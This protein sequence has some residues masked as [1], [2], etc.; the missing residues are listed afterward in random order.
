MRLALA[1]VLL[2]SAASAD[3]APLLTQA[4]ARAEAIAIK[5]C[6]YPEDHTPS[7]YLPGFLWAFIPSALDYATAVRLKRYGG[8]ELDGHGSL[9]IVAALKLGAVLGQAAW[10]KRQREANHGH[11]SSETRRLRAFGVAVNSAGIAVGWHQ[12]NVARDDGERR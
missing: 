7:P 5:P 9:L 1:F 8:H 12:G 6:P 4:K 3:T 11:P 2:A 10:D